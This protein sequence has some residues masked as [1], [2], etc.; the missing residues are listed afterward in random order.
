MNKHF[1]IG[2]FVVA[3]AFST[4]NAETR[5]VSAKKTKTV[6]PIL[7]ANSTKMEIPTIELD[8]EQICNVYS[9]AYSPDGKHIAAGYNNNLIRIWNIQTGAMERSMSGHSGIVW[10]VAYSPDGSLLISGSADRTIKC[11]DPKTGQLIRTLSGHSSTV[12]FVTCNTN[13]VYIASGSTDKTIR[14][15]ETSSGKLLQTLSG[16]TDT[17]ASIT[18]SQSGKF[19]ASASWDRTVKIYHT[20]GG[21]D[22]LTLKG[23]T[24]SV[25]AVEFSPDETRL[26]TGSAD[27][28]MRI[29]DSETGESLQ[30]INTGNGEIWT[31]AYS[32]DG[33][34]IATGASD[35]TV[36]IWEASSGKIR[37]DLKGHIREVRSLCYSKDGKTLYSGD[38][39]GGIKVW[40]SET[41]E[42]IATFL[43]CRDGEWVTWTADGFLNGS[44][45][46]IKRLS[47]TIGGKKY[48][49]EKIKETVYRPALV[50][51]KLTGSEIKGLDESSSLAKLVQLQTQPLVS[52]RVTNADGTERTDDDKR[53]IKAELTITDTGTGIGRILVKLNGRSF[54]IAKSVP[55]KKGES[56]VIDTPSPLS[57]QQGKNTITVSVFDGQ[58]IQETTSNTV[59]MNWVGRSERSRLFILTAGIDDYSDPIIPKLKNCVSDATAIAQICSEYSGDL[60]SD[61]YSKV[62]INK[63]ASKKGLLD[64]IR[65][66]GAASRPDDVFIFYLAGHGMTHS[67]GDYYFIPSD[68]SSKKQQGIKESG[69]SRWQFI[70]S[71]SDIRAAKMVIILDTCNSASFNSGRPPEQ[72]LAG[73]EKSAIIERFATRAGYDLLAA[74]SSYQVAM[75]NYNG[76]GVFTWCLME[77]IQGNADMDS[78][79]QITSTE[80]ALYVIKEVPI[81]SYERFGYRQEPQ[82]SLPLFD[83][84]MFG[85]RNPKE[86]QSLKKAL[87]ISRLAEKEGLSVEEASER[88]R[89]PSAIDKLTNSEE[90]K[91]ASNS[92]SQ[93]N[94]LARG[95]YSM[96]L[97]HSGVADVQTVLTAEAE[98]LINPDHN[99]YFFFATQFYIY[100]VDIGV[101]ALYNWRFLNRP[102]ANYYIGSGADVSFRKLSLPVQ[103]GVIIKDRINIR[104]STA[105][106]FNGY[107]Q[108]TLSV[109]W[110][111]KN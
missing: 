42:A 75:D 95:S 10:S 21:A 35:G 71:L 24:G 78:D 109:A 48:S 99:G 16:H 98:S 64:A 93:F 13:G 81:N 19:V 53:D 26:A 79:G 90:K 107:F 76:H 103:A 1:L 105:W 83:F 100:P 80:L 91:P 56:V 34:Y 25:F 70:E 87:E 77:A 8:K 97:I 96:G 84:P 18:Y 38:S 106:N 33:Q 66:F 86:G 29:W 44:E 27:R 104:Y 55:S 102:S 58:N 22:K 69:I 5:G 82:R 92:I 14:F 51:A 2:V 54:Q 4:V 41:G 72:A 85:K 110:L 65:D 28:T 3:C 60:Y 67:D 12:S 63:E 57:L 108:D 17:I 30:T 9:I 23:H 39:G 11:W 61:V 88:L 62:V 52:F 59:E 7:T 32:P 45:N 37:Y 15:W 43:Q 111:L 101:Q 20:M 49:L 68:Y 36:T 94:N 40:N 31:V 47:Y 50:S 74:C 89:N 73:T 46:A 6:E